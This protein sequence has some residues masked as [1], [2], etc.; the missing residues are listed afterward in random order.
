MGQSKSSPYSQENQTEPDFVSRWSR[1]KH[2]AKQAPQETADHQASSDEAAGKPEKTDGRQVLT[3]ADMPDIDSLT[4]DS[5]FSDFMSPGVS[6]ELRKLALRKLFHSDVF[7]IRDGLNEYD[8]DYTQFEKLGDIVTADMH[9][10]MEMEA[11]RRAEQL[12][13][14][15]GQQA[16]AASRDD[17]D[18]VEEEPV[19]HLCESITGPKGNDDDA[20]P[21]AV[22]AANIT[23]DFDSGERKDTVPGGSKSDE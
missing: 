13:H 6:E 14:D 23:A 20:K 19:E 17:I 11:R 18:S 15:E 12:L 8:D 5:V 2:E 3:D 1:L 22:E 4:F 21:F 10:Q 7:N 9:H 16:D